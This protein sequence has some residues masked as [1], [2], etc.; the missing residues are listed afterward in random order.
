MFAALVEHEASLGAHGLPLDET[1]SP[2]ADPDNPNG[3]HFYVATPVRDWAEQAQIDAESDP[4][5]QGENATHARKW[6]TIRVDR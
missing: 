6:R 5:W 2:L 4:K 3:T 1:M